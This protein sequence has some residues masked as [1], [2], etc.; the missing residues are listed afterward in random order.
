MENSETMHTDSSQV[1]ATLV[2]EHPLASPA[3]ITEMLAL[4]PTGVLV[5]GDSAINTSKHTL[6][7]P[8]SYWRLSSEG[9][10]QSS[11]IEDHLQWV[12]LQI[13]GKVSS[14]EMLREQGADA[15]VWLSVGSSSGSAAFELEHEVI[16]IL[17]TFRI[18]V[19]V[20]CFQVD[21]S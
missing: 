14:F 10:V 9:R 1:Y 3:S 4:K 20:A 19:R 11:I 12:L 16:D 13:S 17:A 8:K 15:H 5:K 6:V 18:S 21:G 2:I 7:S